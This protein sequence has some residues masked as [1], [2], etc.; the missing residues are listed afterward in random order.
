MDRMF[1]LPTFDHEPYNRDTANVTDHPPP[2]NA[3]PILDQVLSRW[4]NVI[5]TVPLVRK[6]LPG[7]SSEWCFAPD[8]RESEVLLAIQ[9]E[10]DRLEDF[11]QPSLSGIPPLK[12]AEIR[13][14]MRIIRSKLDLNRRNRHFVGYSSRNDPEGQI[15][16]SH[17]VESMDRTIRHFRK[18]QDEFFP[19]TGAGG[20]DSR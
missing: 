5:Q 15:G 12:Q 16:R 19:S 17:Y 8:G 14:I 2:N 6:D 10:W 18:L 20:G 3:P 11:I 7:A 1:R 9:E 13:E 4:H